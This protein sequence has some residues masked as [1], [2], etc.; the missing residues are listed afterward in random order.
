M[1]LPESL[2][3]ERIQGLRS[4]RANAVGL[5]CALPEVVVGNTLIAAAIGVD[6]AWIER[7][8][9]IRSR[10]HAPAEMTL[11]ELAAGSAR[12]ALEDA[13][14]EAEELDLLI[15]ATISQERRVPNLA[16]ELA[17]TIGAS[18]AGA[19]DLGAACSGF[20]A[21]LAIASAMIEASRAHHILLV[22]ADMLS[23]HIDPH[24][25]R[26]AAIFGDGAGALV[27][28]AG[29][30]GGVSEAELGADGR[31]AELIAS[32]PESDLIRM[33]G[34]ETFKAAVQT[35]EEGVRS[36][37]ARAAVDPLSDVDLFV[38]HQANGRITR[39]LAERLELPEE[40]VV[41]CIAEVGNTSAASVPLA[42]EQARA[43]GRLVGGSRVVLSAAG[44]GF[45]S[46]A[47]LLEW[48]PS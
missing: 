24:D 29:E 42:L 27:L 39:A 2:A 4:P 13:G 20:V 18:A 25:R 19:F 45:T 9:G 30:S 32:D 1:S 31:C 3:R 21:G 38:F 28:S 43:D 22:G 6:E 8:T 37:C 7:R 35:M 34:P 23:R 48:G 33:D 14:V 10:R 40:K 11:L 16:P 44:A 5:G 26:T 41:D 15:L 12:A 17:S 36:V 47:A 46:A